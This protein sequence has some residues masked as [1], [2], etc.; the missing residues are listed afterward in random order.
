MSNETWP[1]TAKY[2]DAVPTNEISFF[3]TDLKVQDVL[4]SECRDTSDN[5]LANVGAQEGTYGSSASLKL[6]TVLSKY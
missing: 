6:D 1:H 4:Y 3:P 2:H 5:D